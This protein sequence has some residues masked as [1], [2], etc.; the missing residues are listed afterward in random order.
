MGKATEILKA[1]PADVVPK[2]YA[3]LTGVNSS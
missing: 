3:F 1:R 2:I